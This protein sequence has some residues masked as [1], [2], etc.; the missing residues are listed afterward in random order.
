MLYLSFLLGAYVLGV[1]G[2]VQGLQINLIDSLR[3]H[4]IR[5][6]LE[7]GRGWRRLTL[8]CLRIERTHVRLRATSDG[9][10]DSIVLLLSLIRQLEILTATSFHG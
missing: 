1:C 5:P 3:I 2:A 8:E 9:S 10:A 6:L 4:H 7:P